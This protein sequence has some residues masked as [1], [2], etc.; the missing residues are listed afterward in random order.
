[1]MLAVKVRHVNSHGAIDVNRQ[2]GHPVALDQLAEDIKQLLR[3]AHRESR[4]HDAPALR[5]RAFNQRNQASAEVIAWMK[6]VSI[7]RFYEKQVGFLGR[8]RLTNHKL[9]AAADVA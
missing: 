9:M 1:M 6:P 5:S 3:S 7:S 8:L 2:G 4:N